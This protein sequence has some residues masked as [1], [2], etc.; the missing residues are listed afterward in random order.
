MNATW[1]PRECGREAP[2][3]PGVVDSLPRVEGGV[4]PQRVRYGWRNGGRVWNVLP[5][6]P[7]VCV[8]QRMPITSITSG[9]EAAWEVLRMEHS[10]HSVR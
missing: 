2:S 9:A 4:L 10:R 5:L 6:W 1:P 7:G 3:T 8:C